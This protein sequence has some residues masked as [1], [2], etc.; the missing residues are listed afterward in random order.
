MVKTRRSGRTGRRRVR[1]G[2]D[3]RGGR[4]GRCLGGCPP[5]PPCPPCS[6]CPPARAVPPSRPDP[7]LVPKDRT[8]LGDFTRIN[9]VASSIDRV[10][11]AAPTALLIYDPQFKQWHGPFT[12]RDPGTLDRVFAGLV[13]PLDNSLWL[14]RPDGWVHYTPE[15]DLW[16][17]GIAPNT[18]QEIAFDADQ[19]ALGLLLRTPGGWFNVPRGGVSARPDQSRLAA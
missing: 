14:A 12:P 11:A 1:G 7:R 17:R 4:V 8:I 15:L 13:D 3:E 9:A 19:P 2:R 18:V 5:C 6:P 10:Y 16:E